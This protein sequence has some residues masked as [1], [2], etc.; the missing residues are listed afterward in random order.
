MAKET[1][2]HPRLDWFTISPDFT[3]LFM[4]RAGWIFH[5][6]NE[7]SINSIKKARQPLW[8]KQEEEQIE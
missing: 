5:L 4:L 1:W 8:N 3:T 2:H 6:E 7:G